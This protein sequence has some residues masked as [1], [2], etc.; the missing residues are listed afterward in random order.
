[1]QGNFLFPFIL[2]GHFTVLLLIAIKKG[3]ENESAGTEV[4]FSLYVEDQALLQMHTE[5]FLVIFLGGEKKRPEVKVW[6]NRSNR[7]KRVLR[8][9]SVLLSL[10]FQLLLLL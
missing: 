7:E 4:F 1:M 5:L 8:E 9:L 2:S 3:E 10:F 6:E